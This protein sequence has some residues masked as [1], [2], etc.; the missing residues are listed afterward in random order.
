MM[1]GFALAGAGSGVT[2]GTAGC[3]SA[4]GCAAVKWLDGPESAIVP[5]MSLT[6]VRDRDFVSAAAALGVDPAGC[7]SAG[8]SKSARLK[9]IMI[10]PRVRARFSLTAGNQSGVLPDRLATDDLSRPMDRQADLNHNAPA[11]FT[12]EP[13]DDPKHRANRLLM[14]IILQ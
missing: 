10:A 7:A 14:Q 8:T 6:A 3:A 5:A 4:G 13:I 12:L 2:F 9:P 11:R 1:R